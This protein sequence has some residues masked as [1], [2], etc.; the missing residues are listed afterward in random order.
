MHL[1]EWNEKFSSEC[2]HPAGCVGEK[3]YSYLNIYI[4]YYDSV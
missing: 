1:Q 4:L 3:L 2:G